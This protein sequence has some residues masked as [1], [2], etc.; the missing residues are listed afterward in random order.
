MTKMTKKKINNLFNIVRSFYH[1]QKK[2][3]VLPYLPNALWV[4][5]TNVCNLRCIMCPNSVVAQRNPGFMD[6][7]LYKKIIDEAKDYVSYVVLCIS[8]ES[9]LHRQFPQMVKYAKD[10][11]V[12]V[13]VSTNGTVLTSKSSRE[14]LEAGLDWINFSFDGCSKEIYEKIRVNAD[15]DKSLKKIIT[16]LKIKK[17]L[18]AKTQ[19]D[20]QILIMDERGKKDYQE[21]IEKFKNN[22]SQLPLDCV[23]IRQPST[24]GNF[25]SGTEK[26]KPRSLTKE[27]SACSYLWSSLAILWDGR[28]VACCS[29]F[30]GDNVLGKFPQKTLKEIW[31]DKPMRDFR[32]SMANGSYLKY[33]KNCHSCDSLWEKR[34]M[35]FPSGMRGIDA[36]VVKNVFGINI[37]NFFKKLSK[38]LNKNFFLEVVEQDK[39]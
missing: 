38:L 17:E 24:W 15:F 8:G 36:S 1:Y 28:V 32:Q 13:Y 9:L 19:A 39:K 22:F 4:E 30:F 33:N 35:G 23:Q 7:N 20:L 37:L 14:I 5:P 27:F 18:K 11:K 10:N 3:F 25:F 34:I 12:A 2:D 6:I 16:F 26:F 21:N 29:D 31:N